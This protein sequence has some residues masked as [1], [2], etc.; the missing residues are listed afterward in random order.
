VVI[1]LPHILVTGGLGFIGSHLVRR[2]LT[3]GNDYFVYNVD[4]ESY[5]SNHMNLQ[6]FEN[7]KSYSYQRV[8][9]NDISKMPDLPKPNIIINVAS[10]TH[11][12]RSIS[13]PRGFMHS[14]FN[15]TFELLEY[16]RKN[17]VLK[18]VQV[19]TDEVYGEA[20]TNHEFKESDPVNPGNP[21]S[22]AKAAADLLVKSYNRT[23]GL[24]VVITRC[25]NNFGP[26]Q[27]P[28]KLIPKTIISTIIGSPI[29]VYGDGLQVRDWI[30]VENHVDAL[31][32]AM[33]E[34]RRGE[35]YNVST[36]NLMTN[37]DIIS[38]VQTLIKNKT[39]REGQVV[40][41]KDRPGHD[42]R[43]SINSD[44]L[45]EQLG[46]KR[47]I[48]FEDALARTI[49]WY[50]SNEKWWRPLLNQNVMHPRPWEASWNTGGQE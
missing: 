40:F 4:N 37:L 35:I 15:G 22:A 1:I 48:A 19:S 5:G 14:N 10:E 24:D 26:N 13:N 18:Y 32:S 8:D 46:W 9:I 28:E 41:V 39:G 49:E 17:D 7:H 38:K 25:S 34:G 2:L 12:D 16:A 33:R 44:K 3:S 42:R 47:T 30:F 27:F 50:L 43:Y 21:Y 45:K 36:R 20:P 23:Y 6:G 31:L 11:V 29:Y